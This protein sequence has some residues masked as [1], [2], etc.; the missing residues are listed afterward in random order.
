MENVTFNLEEMA[1]QSLRLSGG[2]FCT[3]QQLELETE[4]IRIQKLEAENKRMKAKIELLERT[5]SALRTRILQ[6][7]TYGI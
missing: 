7:T 4:M 6:I 5:N 1:S 2:R 3:R